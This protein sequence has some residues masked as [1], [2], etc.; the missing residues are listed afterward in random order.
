M[1]VILLSAAT[2]DQTA[3]DI[4]HLLIQLVN[5]IKNNNLSVP[6]VSNLFAQFIQEKKKTRMNNPEITTLL[7][8]IVGEMNQNT[9]PNL[10]SQL[11]EEKKKTGISNSEV[12]DFLTQ[13]IGTTTKKNT[14]TAPEVSSL[15]TQYIGDTLGICVYKYFLNI[16][17]DKELQSILEFALQQAESHVTQITKFCQEAKFQVPIGLTEHDVNPNA[18]RLFSDAFLAKYTATMS[19][20]GLNA[21]SLSITTAERED[22]RDYY[23]ECSVTTKEILNKTVKYRQSKGQFTN[24]PLIPSPEQVKFDEKIGIISNLFGDKRPLNASEINNVFF[25]V[26]KATLTRALAVAFSQ[27]AETEDVRNYMLETVEIVG[28]HIENFSNILVKEYL[29]P[30]RMYENE[31]TDST[32]SPFSDKLMM[33]QMAFLR[34]ST[35]VYFGT[36]LASSM[37]PDIIV[38]YNNAIQTTITSSK[39][40]FDVLLK[41]GWLE[42]QPESID[43]KS[44]AQSANK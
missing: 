14:L 1:E 43:R 18:P 29:K 22:I 28:K 39:S 42:K 10:F 40:L 9:L 3:S 34:N 17:E 38:A 24:A 21:Y 20:H 16:V 25:T 13:I 44:L 41:Y 35:L 12:T 6:E 31:V 30:P 19:M 37:R 33:L 23:N 36:G 15:W 26:K 7:T 27:V 4:A 32:V 11:I 8:Q 5:E 2:I